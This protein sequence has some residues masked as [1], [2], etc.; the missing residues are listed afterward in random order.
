MLGYGNGE[1]APGR[2]SADATEV[3]RAGH[4]ILLAHARAVNIY[5]TKFQQDQGGVIGIT[6]NGNWSGV[7]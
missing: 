2:T 7:P 1:H 4:N 3:Y 6:L 5:R